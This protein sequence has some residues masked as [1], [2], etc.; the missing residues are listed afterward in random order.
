MTENAHIEDYLLGRI[1]PSQATST[2]TLRRALADTAGCSPFDVR[3]WPLEAGDTDVLYRVRIPV[4][5]RAT[6]LSDAWS[7]ARLSSLITAE[8]RARVIQGCREL[9]PQLCAASRSSRTHRIRIGE[10]LLFAADVCSNRCT[11]HRASDVLASGPRFASSQRR[12][13]ALFAFN[14]AQ[15]WLHETLSHAGFRVIEPSCQNIERA[16]GQ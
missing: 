7:V 13:D 14:W 12:R 6:D 1:G 11:L 5:A 9:W 10:P 2:V 8:Q 3:L 15:Q 4:T 16:V